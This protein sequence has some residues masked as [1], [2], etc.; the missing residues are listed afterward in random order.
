M[1]ID[2][3]ELSMSTDSGLYTGLETVILSSHP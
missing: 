3:K 2:R 1:K